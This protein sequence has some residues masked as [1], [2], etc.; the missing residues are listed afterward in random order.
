MP[1]T[2][3]ISYAYAKACG[4]LGKSFVG[5]RLKLLTNVSRLADIERLVFTSE[6]KNISDKELVVDMEE[7][8]EERSLALL[9]QIIQS[10]RQPGDFLSLLCRWTEFK[11]KENDYYN[12]LWPALMHLPKKDRIYTE[13]ILCEEIALHNAVWAMRLRAYYKMNV[14]DISGKLIVPNAENREMFRD[15]DKKWLSAAKM[16]LELPEDD[17]NAWKIWPYYKLLNKNAPEEG[18]EWQ[19]DPRYVQNAVARKLFHEAYSGFRRSPFSLDMVY[20]FS[21]IL[22]FEED[23]LTGLCG[24]LG[25]GMSANEFANEIMEAVPNVPS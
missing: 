5:K 3:E 11:N 18:H 15:L 7:R 2:G 12:L 25:L 16:A 6:Q 8:I 22:Q 10:F 21:K 1:T 14:D 20:C 23:M 4:I 17:M 13:K 24:A 19:P 9:Q